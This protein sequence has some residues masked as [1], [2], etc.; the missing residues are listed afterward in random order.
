MIVRS[1][2]IHKDIHVQLDG[3]EDLGWPLI[4]SN[5]WPAK[6]VHKMS[7]KAYL[8]KYNFLP[9]AG[10]LSV[11]LQGLSKVLSAWNLY[12]QPSGTVNLV[13]SWS[14][15][16]GVSYY[17]GVLYISYSSGEAFHPYQN[18]RYRLPRPTYQRDRLVMHPKKATGKVPLRR[19]SGLH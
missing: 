1:R 6:L 3:G 9:V 11:D 2:Y 19:P 12:M 14:S 8:C 13:S 18:T 7:S 5:M 17:Q 10:I 16:Y 15:T 4:T